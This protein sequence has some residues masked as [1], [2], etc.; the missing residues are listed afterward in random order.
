MAKLNGGTQA[1]MD[2]L[3]CQKGGGG[4]EIVDRTKPE[5]DAGTERMKEMEF[6]L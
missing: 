4:V 6:K 5:E 1:A 3:K 2:K